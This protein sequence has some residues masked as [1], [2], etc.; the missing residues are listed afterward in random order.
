MSLFAQ[1]SSPFS[2]MTLTTCMGKNPSACCL[3]TKEQ[4]AK[5]SVNEQHNLLKFSYDSGAEVIV[6]EQYKLVRSACNMLW[7]RDRNEVLHILD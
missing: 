5:L 4:K 7:M 6:S 3:S 2:G 1:P